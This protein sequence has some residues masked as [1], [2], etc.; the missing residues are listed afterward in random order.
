MQSAYPIDVT[1]NDL[2]RQNKRNSV[3]LMIAMGALTCGVIS[4]IGIMVMI[5]GEGSVSPGGIVVA[6]AAG[7]A[8]TIIA[9]SWSYFSGGKTLLS[10][11]GAR[12]IFH[13][14]DPELFNVVEELAIAAGLPVPKVY[15][16]ES[17]ALNAFATGRDPQHAAVAIT[18]GLREKL[19][20][21]Q[22]QAVMAHEMAHVR[23]LDIRLTMLV[24][25]MVGLIVL[26][27]D[28]MLR[29]SFYGNAGR[30]RRSSNDKGGGAAA[31]MLVLA[32]VLAIVAPLLATIIQFAVSRQREYLADA[33]AVELT[34]DPQAMADALRSLTADHTPL[35]TASR[36]T[37]H[38]YIV[39]P[40]MNAKH[41]ENRNSVF[42]T[43]PPISERIARLEA[44][45]R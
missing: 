4:L 25:T 9:S 7:I 13:A 32:L 29:A 5:Y 31:L 21:N 41:Q 44:L 6:V 34:R 22:M 17:P 30:S 36:A 10:L 16:I 1:F 19:P 43:H 15:L 11:S 2:I 28:V 35:E 37:A 8:V 12:E 23:H 42:S 38:M 40:L 33:G 20:R 14:D 27:C 26:A 24:A 18:R 3:L 39:N 45:L